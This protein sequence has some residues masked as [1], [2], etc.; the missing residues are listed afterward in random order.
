MYLMKVPT[1]K[2]CEFSGFVNLDVSELSGGEKFFSKFKVCKCV[3]VEF[4]QVLI[5]KLYK[6]SH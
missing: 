2:Y 1:G 3:Y 6:I 5:N 4:L